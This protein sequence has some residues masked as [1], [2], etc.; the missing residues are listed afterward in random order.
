MNVANAAVTP[1]MAQF[2][3]I[4]ADYPEAVLFYRMG[5]FYEMFFDDARAAAAALDIALTKRGKHLGADIPMCGVP[6]HAAEAYLLTL[7]RKGFRVAVCEQMEDPAEAK[8][9]GSKSVV[10]REVVR[11]VTPGTLTED[12][13]LEPRRHNYLAAWTEVRGRG[14]LAWADI[15]T[16]VFR[17]ADCARDRLGFELARLVPRE[18]LISQQVEDDL[19]EIGSDVDLALTPRAASS[20]DSA[21]GEG[22]LKALFCVAAL[23]AFGAFTRSELGA[24]GGL[25]DYLELTQKGNLPILRPPRREDAGTA[26]QIDSATRRNLELAKALSGG[27]EGTLISVIDRTVTAGG[28]RLLERRLAAPLRDIA[29]ISARHDTVAFWLENRALADEMRQVLRRIPDMDRAMARIS[30]GRAGPRDLAAVRD[31]MTQAAALDAGLRGADPPTELADHCPALTGSDDLIAQLDSALVADP[32]LLARDGGFIAPGYDAE[33]DTARDLRDHGR[34]VIAA[35]QAEYSRKSGIT[36]LKV[37]H[38]NVLGYF[39]ETP[40]KHAEKMLSPP[41]S[42]RFIHRQTTANAMRFTTID[43]REME[44]EI[45]N[46]GGRAL[47]IELAHYQSLTRAVLA[48]FADIGAASE[49]LAVIDV[50]SALADLARGEVWSRPIVDDSRALD[51][52]AGRHPVVETAL[53]REG[54]TGFVANDCA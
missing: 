29:K 17:V 19:A 18:L 14:A 16:G 24:M 10:R 15:S 32:P 21:R 54:G 52:T 5:D 33:L 53:A 30:L 40:A 22:R 28:A 20:F 47:A 26:V 50:S 51:I 48:K 37:K 2:L 27:R 44:T 39:V 13:L 23:D 3:Q 25:V 1:M 7:I 4:K 49:A 45:L 6:V 42:D 11:L 43:L 34:S 12:A 9:R 35:M 38:N 41:L 8:K 36:A 46:A 31:G